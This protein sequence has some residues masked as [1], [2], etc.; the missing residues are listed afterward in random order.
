EAI[1]KA[2]LDDPTADD[3][4]CWTREYEPLAVNGDLGIARGGARYRETERRPAPTVYHNIWLVELTDDGRC[5]DF[6][7]HF[8]ELPAR[9]VEA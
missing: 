3:P 1:V 8:M 5:R 7:E 2:W 6:T 4:T 9:L